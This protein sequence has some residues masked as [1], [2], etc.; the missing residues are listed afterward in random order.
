MELIIGTAIVAAAKNV[1][2]TLRE[3]TCCDIQALK[4]AYARASKEVSRLT[5]AKGGAE[6][7][8]YGFRTRGLG[9]DAVPPYSKTD[10]S[11]SVH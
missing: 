11:E 9:C 3:V 4:R 2:D 8:A 10:V 5:K 1:M 6:I 7:T